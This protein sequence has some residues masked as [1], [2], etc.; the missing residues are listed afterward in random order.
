MSSGTPEAPGASTSSR[1]A[2]PGCSKLPVRSARTSISPPAARAGGIGVTADR[3][4]FGVNLRSTVTATSRC[5]TVSSARQN[6]APAAVS[7]PT[8]VMSR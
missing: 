7:D 3:A 4:A 1:R 2:Q 5:S 8:R 6:S